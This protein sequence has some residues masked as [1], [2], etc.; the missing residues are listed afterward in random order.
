MALELSKKCFRFWR[1][2]L[3]EM[4]LCQVP[5]KTL[6]IFSLPISTQAVLIRDPVN[7]FLPSKESV[8]ISFAEVLIVSGTVSS[9]IRSQLI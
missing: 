6:S 3:K 1:P 9:I 4:V 2:Y 7:I 8:A 5:S